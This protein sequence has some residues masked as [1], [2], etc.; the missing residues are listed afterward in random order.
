[1][2]LNYSVKILIPDGERILARFVANCLSR[3]KNIELHIISKD[4]DA[5][6][7]YSRYIK[8]F[9]YFDESKN[10]RKWLSFIL[11]QIKSKRIDVI[12]PVEIEDISLLAEFIDE[13]K[14]LVKLLIPPK[15]SF[16]ITLDKWKFFKYLWRNGINTPL[17]FNNLEAY[18]QHVTDITFPMLMKPSIGMGG[19]GITKVSTIESM[20]EVFDDKKNFMAQE[21]VKGYDI[22]MSVLCENGKILAY[23]IQKGYIF[24]TAA[25]SAPLGMEFLY[26][27]AIFSMVGLMM[28]KLEWSGFAH[29]DL[30]YDELDDEFKI[31][32]VNPRTWGSIEASKSVGVNFPLLYIMSSLGITY[33]I[34]K[35]KFETCS[36]N[37]G[38]IKVIKSKFDRNVQ[39]LSFPNHKYQLRNILDPLPLIKKYLTSRKVN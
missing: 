21:L 18:K 32:E 12:M 9:T 16:D 23:T 11:D 14:G 35:Y 3:C 33:D 27:E 24:S 19:F 13:F 31:L 2:K 25:Y 1:M 5:V 22:D 20:K 10:D 37:I 28:E 29:I 30:M 4:A 36:G 15:N 26:D 6:I 39:S 8:S 34:P 17:S 7:K 38:L